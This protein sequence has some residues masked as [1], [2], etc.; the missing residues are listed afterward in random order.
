MMQLILTTIVTYMERINLF[1]DWT[2]RV[3]HLEIPMRRERTRPTKG[4]GNGG[5]D[6]EKDEPS[7]QTT[8][9]KAVQV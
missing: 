2:L 9:A 4:R 6:H 8:T 3:Q 5:D 7:V 1:P